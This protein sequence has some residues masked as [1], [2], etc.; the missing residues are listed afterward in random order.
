M[1][2]IGHITNILPSIYRHI[3]PFIKSNFFKRFDTILNNL[4]IFHEQCNNVCLMKLWCEHNIIPSWN[5]N[6]LPPQMYYKK[7]YWTPYYLQFLVVN[8]YKICNLIYFHVFCFLLAGYILHACRY[9]K[10]FFEMLLRPLEISLIVS[11]KCVVKCAVKSAVICSG[12]FNKSI[13]T[14]A[15]LC[16]AN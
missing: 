6:S 8:C 13:I 11:V 15:S 14:T 16:E 7:M 3:L 4:S 9:T 1:D 2:F 12:N 5:C 10:S